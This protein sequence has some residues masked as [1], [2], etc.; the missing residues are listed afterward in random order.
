MNKKIFLIFFFAF[1]IRLIAL[2]QSLWLDES[3]TANVVKS[4]GFTQIISKFSPTD[5]HPPLYYLFMKLWTN[6]FGFSEIGLRMPSV[7]FSLMT[8]WVIYLIGGTWAAA[9]FLFNPLIIYYSQ[10]A[11]MYMMATFF[12]TTALYYF[13]RISRSLDSRLRG[14]DI[15]FGLFI[16]LAFLTFYGSIFLISAMLLYL[17]F[18]K[19]YKSFFVSCS[20]FL[21][22]FVLISP[23]LYQQFL[24]SKIALASVANWSLV[25][26]KANIKN[27]LLIPIKFSIGRISFYP[28]WLY[29]GIAGMWTGFVALL[30]I[31]KLK[32]KNSFDVAQDK[33][34]LDS[35]IKSLLFLLLLPLFLGFL[36]SF[37]APMM[38]YF[39]FIYLIPIM[40]I[41]LS[42]NK[43]TSMYRYIEVLGFVIFSLVY[44]SLPQFHRE[45]WRS[46]VKNLPKDKPVYMIT[47]SS[48]PVKYYNKN[49]I[50]NELKSLSSSSSLSRKIIII[51]YVTEIYGLDYKNL[52]TKAGYHFKKEVSF[53]EVAYEQW[54]K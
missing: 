34:N 44:L 15:L 6:L 16:S 43:N 46:L 5:F 35:K 27:L 50:I 28:K 24:N 2:N 37:F 10:E 7:L 26:G 33:Q 30:L 40:A 38:Q 32:V 12:L 8:G 23:L 3:V 54:V 21:V 20:L 19:E 29:W 1:I 11:R 41:L 51:P 49:L 45:D 14:N 42:L 52:L 36:V 17:L 25:L 39:R 22:S 13:L 47:A 53:R 9:F 18:K 4:F 48:D 31:Q